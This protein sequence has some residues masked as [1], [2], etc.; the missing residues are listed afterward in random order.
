MLS[1]M[2]SYLSGKSNLE[3]IFWVVTFIFFVCTID[4]ITGYEISFSLFYLLPIAF[5]T[6]YLSRNIG[7]FFCIISALLWLTVDHYTDHKYSNNLIPI[8]NSLVRF[9]F[10]IV[11]C[12]LLSEIKRHLQ[13]EQELARTDGLTGLLNARTFKRVSTQS[14]KL[15]S[16]YKY[17]VTIGVI[18]VDNFKLLNDSLGHAAGD[19][20]LKMIAD[21][22]TK[23]IRAT[24]ISGRIGGDEF[25]IVLPFT[26]HDDVIKIFDNLLNLLQLNAFTHKWPIGFSIGVANFT[27]TIPTIEAAILQADSLMYR[28]KKTG[29]G[30]IIYENFLDETENE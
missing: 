25:A 15:A 18:D 27:H 28:V 22:I 1:K 6:W 16:R 20:A 3:K 29:K 12:L 7:I 9:G 30:S 17:P 2:N 8:W 24:D 4:F 23:S 5:A 26:H 11:T 14:F 19:K 21:T 13:I 10:F